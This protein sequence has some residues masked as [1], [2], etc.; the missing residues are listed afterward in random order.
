[1]KEPATAAAAELKGKLAAMQAERERQDK[2]FGPPTT[3]SEVAAAAPEKKAQQ[4]VQ[5]VLPR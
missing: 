5:K 4:Q 3:F 2:I 1:V